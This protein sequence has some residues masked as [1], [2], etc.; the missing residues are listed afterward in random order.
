MKKSTIAA[1][2]R[3]DIEKVWNIVTDNTNYA[4]RSD[5]SRIVAS[6]DGISFTEHTK[7]GFATDFTIT[8][9]EPQ[10]QYEFDISN[11]NI[12]GHW[13]GIFEKTLNGTKIEFTEEVSAKNPIMN[14]FLGTYLKKRG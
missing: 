13:T 10:K 11:K 14:L 4:W 1:V 6:D 5:L 9:K 8:K 3:S 2:F 7:D 12:T